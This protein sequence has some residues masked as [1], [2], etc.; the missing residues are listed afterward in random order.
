MATIDVHTCPSCALRFALRTELD[1]HIRLEHLAPIPHDGTEVV[2][3]TGLMTVP[4]DPLRINTSAV[5][6]AAAVARQAQLAVELVAVRPR[7]LSALPYLAAR[8]H[9][10]T[11]SHT[12]CAGS[13]E[14]PEGDKVDGLLEHIA[15]S[16]PHLVCMASHARTALGEM[17][18]GST[19]EALA[20]RSPVPVLLVGPAV[21]QVPD[22]VRRVV[23]C[24]DGSAGAEHAL[25]AAEDLAR[26]LGVDLEMVEVVSSTPLPGDVAET[27]YLR[28]VARRLA[29]PPRLYDTLH[30]DHPAQSI[31]THAN[32]A[33]D[34]IFAVGTSGRSGVD[35]L[36]IGSVALGVVRHSPGP[37]LIVSQAAGRA[38][39]PG[40]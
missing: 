14:L 5:E 16:A 36:L 37:V 8:A 11:G 35:A 6:V 31:V 9:E 26:R 10:L 32:G 30:G 3:A 23:A 29:V 33:A 12:A 18:F 13:V 21:K 39:A 7:G 17:T 20:R 40:R 24:L 28:E 38:L 25:P 1:D 34:T 4:V 2:H 27:A 19:S 22:R 15:S